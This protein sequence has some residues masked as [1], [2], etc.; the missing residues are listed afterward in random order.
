V[1]LQLAPKMLP[2]SL[3]AFWTIERNHPAI[4]SGR[5]SRE[6]IL[7]YRLQFLREVVRN[8]LIERI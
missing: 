4:V 5:F 8:P 1:H 7:R 6:L 2:A 3:T